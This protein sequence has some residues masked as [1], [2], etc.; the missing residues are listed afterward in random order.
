MTFLPNP[1]NLPVVDHIN[2]NKL[3]NKVNN[4]RWVTQKKNC[5]AYCDNFRT[6]RK[7]LQFNLNGKLKSYYGY[8]WEWGLNNNIDNDWN[9][10]QTDLNLVDCSDDIF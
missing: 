4:L 7:I 1:K 6:Y 8:F 2:N 5:Q 10:T 9:I 3:N